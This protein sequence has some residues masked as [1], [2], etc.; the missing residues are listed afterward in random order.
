MTGLPDAATAHAWI[1]PLDAPET[2]REGLEQCLSPAEKARL[3]ACATEEARRR[4]ILGRGVLRHLLSRYT[5]VAAPDLALLRGELG[6][7]YLGTDDS[8]HFSLSH[9]LDTAVVALARDETGVDVEH[10]RVPARLDRIARRVLHPDTVA[11][12][13]AAEDTQRTQLFLEAWT[14]REAHVKA[15][16][17]GLFHTPDTVPFTPGIPADGVLRSVRERAGGSEWSL[18]R[19]RPGDGLRAAVVVRGAV[20]SLVIHDAGETRRLIMEAVS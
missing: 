10:D 4:F 14:L 19:F 5:G 1:V 18:A 3:D 7:P 16:G 6:K 8:L 11:L 17:G 12:L 20:T 13:D 9:S 2:L 15:I